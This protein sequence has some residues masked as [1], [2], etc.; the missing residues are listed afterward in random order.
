MVSEVLGK[1]KRVLIKYNKTR[2]FLKRKK[3][4]EKHGQ[5]IFYVNY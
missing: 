4:K 3:K 2:F 5:G 1:K